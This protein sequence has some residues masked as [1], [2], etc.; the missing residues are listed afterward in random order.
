MSK[1][2]T[3]KIDPNLNPGYYAKRDI[4][5]MQA[6]NF[7]DYYNKRHGQPPKK[8]A[9]KDRVDRI[10]DYV[11]DL[12][13]KALNNDV[14]KFISKIDVSVNF[15][16]NSFNICIGKQGTSKTTSVMKELI[17]L[18]ML[19]NDYHMIL[20]VTNNSSDDTVNS[21]KDYIE[22]PM[23][24][25][26]YESIED[27]F[28]ELIQLK[29]EYNKMVDGEIPK[30]SSILKPLMIKNFNKKRLHT[31]ILFDDAAFIFDKKSKSQF[32]RWLLQCRHLNVTAFCCLQS[33]TSIDNRLKEQ[34]SSIY[35]FKGFSKERLQ[36]IHR[37]INLDIDFD[38][39][40]N[41][42]QRLKKYSKLVI[43][44][45]DGTFKIV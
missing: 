33:W 32:K 11:E 42:Y 22:I 37:Q 31:F 8:S 4:E 14:P 6:N 5:L 20:Y 9:Q 35:L 30:D 15:R 23:I 40:Y 34:L 21:L 26:N 24:K 1:S 38:E 17:K 41:L 25:T 43:D 18:S 27:Q 28:E 13:D 29:D 45:I 2:K 7:K 3:F 36:Y 10:N 44:C 16:Y 12:V 39:F 19:P